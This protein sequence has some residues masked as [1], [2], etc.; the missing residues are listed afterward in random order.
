MQILTQSGTT[1]YDHETKTVTRIV[2]SRGYKIDLEHRL[3]N[4]YNHHD[5]LEL[6]N[7]VANLDSED[8]KALS[9]FQLM[10]KGR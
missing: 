1:E 8:F 2:T 5:Q 9:E 6:L 3:P 4:T 7:A 10:L